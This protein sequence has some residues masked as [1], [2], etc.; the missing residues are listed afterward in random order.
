MKKIFLI[1]AAALFVAALPTFSQA[2]ASGQPDVFVKTVPILKIYTHELGYKILFIKS[3]QEVGSLYVPIKWFGRSAGK[4]MAVFES[5]GVSPYMSLFWE[6]GK[7][8]HIILHLPAST[9]SPVWGMLV[10][11]EDMTSV[12]NIEEPQVSF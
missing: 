6:N 9:S 5:A 10:T 4:G 2:Q 12:F 3:T 8:N 7:F 1:C 11:N